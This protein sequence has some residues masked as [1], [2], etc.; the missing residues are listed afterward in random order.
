MCSTVQD[1][2]YCRSYWAFEHS[3]LNFDQSTVLCSMALAFHNAMESDDEAL[4]TLAHTTLLQTRS[5]E[6]LGLRPL[7]PEATLGGTPA[8]E[9]IC[10]NFVLGR[11][12]CTCNG[13]KAHLFEKACGGAINAALGG[14]H[15]CR[16]TPEQ[17]LHAHP[18]PKELTAALGAWWSAHNGGCPPVWSV[19]APLASKE[20]H[21]LHGG[22]RAVATASGMEEGHGGKPVTVPLALQLERLAKHEASSAYV[23]RFLRE[24]FLEEFRCSEPLRSLLAMRKAAKEVSEAYGAIACARELLAAPLAAGRVGVDGRGVVFLDVCSGRGLTAVL[25][26]FILPGARVVLF[27]ANGAMDLAHVAARPQLRFCHLDLFG[28]SASGVLRQAAEGE[29]VTVVIA[30]GT[31]LCGALSPRLIDLCVRVPSIHGLVLSP[32][33]LRG[34]LGAKISQAAKRRRPGRPPYALLV[35]T[36]AALCARLVHE[37]APPADSPP[38][39]SPIATAATSSHSPLPP[40]LPPPLPVSSA[41]AGCV[42]VQVGFRVDGAVVGG[43]PEAV[44][45][46]TGGEAAVNT[47]PS[48]RALCE[49]CLDLTSAEARDAHQDAPLASAVRVVWDAEVLSPVNAFIVLAMRAPLNL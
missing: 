35:E 18:D 37:C 5:N 15:I 33:C 19:A 9:Y 24:P 14:L 44:A 36:L 3:G 13:T 12:A 30:L 34:A 21:A 40:P 48:A 17:C 23:H 45:L 7:V 32:C 16:R 20:N 31:H 46:V 26:S 43:L 25:L 8:T 6:G 2:T 49:P 4:I 39:S 11:G 42:E 27:D 41:Q 29:G 1:I 38:P 28:A 10:W 22:E 47:T